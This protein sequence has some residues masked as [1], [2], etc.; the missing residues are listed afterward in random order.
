MLFVCSGNSVR[1]PMA[2][3]LLRHH[4]NHATVTS[5]G[6]RPKPDLHPDAVR[7][8][9]EAFGIDLTGHRPRGVDTLTSRFT[10]VITLCDKAREACPDFG[11]ARRIHWSIPEPAGYPAFRHTAA[12]IDTRIRHLLPTLEVQP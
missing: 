4:A 8:L 11:E 12:E 9:R 7:V 1:S 3:A 6:T 5:A 2:E 10:H